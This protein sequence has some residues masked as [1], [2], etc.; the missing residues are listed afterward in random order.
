MDSTDEDATQHHP[1]PGRD[2]AVEDCHG[3]TDDRSCTGYGGEVVGKND[4][5]LGRYIVTAVIIE[6]GRGGVTGVLTE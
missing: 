2:E 6:L 5:A 4:V 3:G 1:E